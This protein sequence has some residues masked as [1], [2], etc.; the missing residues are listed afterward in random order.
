MTHLSVVTPVY[1]EDA[2]TLTVLVQQLIEALAAITSDFEILFVDDGSRND[3][4]Q[5]ISFLAD[6]SPHVRGL[7]LLR[8]FGQHAAIS[9]GLDHAKGDWVVVMDSDLQDRPEIISKLYAK[10]QD[11]YDVVFVN[12]QRRPE[13]TLYLFLSGIFYSTLNALAGQ[14]YNRLQGNFSII[15]RAAVTAFRTVPDRD[16]FYGGTLHWLGFPSATID[17]AHGHRFSG[18]PSYTFKTRLRFAGRL[19]IGHSTRL[20][21]AAIIFGGLMGL[22]SFAMAGWVIAHKILN[23]D[24]P[25]PGWPSVMTAV[26]FAAG[27]TNVMIGLVGIYLAELFAWSKGRPRYLIGQTVGWEHGT[28]KNLSEIKQDPLSCQTH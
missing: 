25:V 19:I 26:F 15:S 1:N 28:Q 3:A 13:G 5:T 16:R 9:A 22:A 12:R 10:A 7:R 24:L 27:M 6:Q 18:K 14:N 8:N 23:P 21:Y 20:L 2:S 17:A 4:W 11:R